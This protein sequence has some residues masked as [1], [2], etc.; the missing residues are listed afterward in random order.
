MRR[1]RIIGL[2]L[3]ALLALGAFAASV[4]SAEEGVL[5]DT[6]T[7]SAE[8]GAGTLET[9]NKEKISCTKI[10]VLEIKATTDQKGTATLHLS[11]CLAEGAF[12]VSSLGDS[13]GVILSRVNL[14]ACLIEPKT[15]VFGLLIAAISLPEHV[16]IPSVGQL[17]LVKGALI[18]RNQSA[19][20]G[21]EFEGSLKGKE[22]KQTEATEC[23]I[24][25]TKFKHSFESANDK[26]AK[27]FP[28]SLE[29]RLTVKLNETVEF[30]DT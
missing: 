8:G 4:A 15:L 10:T 18:A 21:K 23:E 2:V 9:T 17:L 30:M 11:G 16:E 29:G 26:N 6:A 25:G 24:N 13:S 22:G 12:P 5:P 27:D 20:K 28:A 7:G 3:L 14:L 19:N 1:L